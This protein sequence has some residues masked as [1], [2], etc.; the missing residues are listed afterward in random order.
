MSMSG[1]PP[2]DLLDL[3]EPAEPHDR[4]LPAPAPTREHA[5]IR[6]FA[7]R[8]IAGPESG[9]RVVSQSARVLVG[10]HPTAELR[11]SDRTV[12]RFHCE[13]ALERG[14]VIVRDLSSKNGT[15]IDGVEV[16]AAP[17]RHGATLTLG[18][19]Q[20]RFELGDEDVLV[21][22]SDRVE[23]GGAVGGSP[24]MR[25][26]FAVLEHAAKSD[27]TVLLEGETGT[28]KDVLAQAVH[29]ESARR[30]GPFVVVDCGALPPG[31]LE[32][33]LFGHER[34]AFTGADTARE[35]AFEAASGGTLFLDEIGE[36]DLELQ[37]KLL[38]A[39]ERREVRRVGS[40]RGRLV[41]V[42]VVAATS[43]RLQVEVN[44][45]RFRSDLYYR[46]A[47][48]AVKVPPLRER[49]DDLP[50]LCERLLAELCGGVSAGRAA[51][52][53]LCTPVFMTALARHEWP[54]N[55]RELRNYLERCLV[56][57]DAGPPG[58]DTPVP[59]A[60]PPIDPALPLGDAR[61][62][63]VEWFERKYLEELLRRH[64]GNVTSAAKAAGIGRAQ[65]Y[66]LL[67]RAGLR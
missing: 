67:W 5:L 30:D 23:L 29:A 50:L 36:L 3:S 17:L 58:G 1:P 45:G 41:D 61:Q 53:R 26:L 59:G 54:G 48:V 65:L 10:T 24:P 12:S 56:V 11:L 43:R 9:T 40:A 6:R 49:R 14:R 37:P 21:P 60:M 16:H 34:G 55:V 4:T 27:A 32:S 31:L 15:R 20:L 35:G 44:A 8:V 62:R 19:T 57:S 25:A 66:R 38:G 33:E 28:G 64:G 39:L 18:D 42:R 47:V 51:Q 13:L 2:D 7:L 63:H 52:A 46:L 22:L